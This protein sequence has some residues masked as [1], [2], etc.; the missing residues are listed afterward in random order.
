MEP[1]RTCPLDYR[2]QPEML[3]G[4]PALVTDTLYVVGGLYGNR[5]ALDAIEAL[6]ARE[7]APVAIVFNGDAHWFDAE[8][9]P[10]A[11]LEER[12]ARFPAIRG[13]VE[14]ELGKEHAG[15]AGCGCAYPETV[16]QATVERSN[17]IME[18]LQATAA[19]VPGAKARFRALPPLMTAAVGSAR[20]GIV[21]GD[22]TAIAGWGFSREKLDDSRSRGWIGQVFEAADV[23]IFACTHTCGAVMRRFDVGGALKLVA[24]NGAAGMGNFAGSHAGVI[25]RIAM[26]P[27]PDRPLY[28]ARL[29]GLFIEAV[30][31]AFD[32]DA[33]LAEF[34]AIWPNASPAAL[35]YRARI[36]G[37]SRDTIAG[38][39]AEKT[40]R[41]PLTSAV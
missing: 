33:F 35:S 12:L 39:R 30:A 3:A 25:T 1:G 22:P 13:N 40:L 26:R 6:A 32:L 5:F 10:F 19:L 41:C 20:I 28:S 2:T 16:D 8:P 7:A 14:T 23:D 29:A 36:L 38:A 15:G 4:A 21:H 27:A 11:A 34:D 17:A 31:V 24:N 37:G 18:R 9:E